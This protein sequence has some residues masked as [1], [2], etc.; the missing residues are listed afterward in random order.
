MAKEKTPEEFA[1]W[2]KEQLE[3]IDKSFDEVNRDLMKTIN[4]DLDRFKKDFRVGK[5]KNNT[6]TKLA[7]L[8]YQK[9]KGVHYICGF[10]H[11]NPEVDDNPDIAT[12][13]E[14]P[15]G[16]NNQLKIGAHTITEGLKKTYE[17]F[18]D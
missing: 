4:E 5:R 8:E 13:T 11:D 3:I 9:N 12:D 1:K 10:V 14:F 6:L 17:K 2:E 16:I 18:W 7:F 15:I